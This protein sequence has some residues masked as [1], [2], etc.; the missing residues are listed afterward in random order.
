MA[1]PS[2]LFGFFRL[3]AGGS[4]C[5]DYT[6]DLSGLVTVEST[7]GWRVFETLSM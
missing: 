1:A 4:D 5:S 3:V 6:V 2:G 7:G